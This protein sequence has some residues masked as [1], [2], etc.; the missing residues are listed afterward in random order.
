MLARQQPGGTLLDWRLSMILT[1][2]GQ[3]EEPLFRKI[4]EAPG[5]YSD[6]VVRFCRDGVST[7]PLF[8]GLARPYG[9]TA[10]V[11]EATGG[12]DDPPVSP[13]ASS[14]PGTAVPTLFPI[15]RVL[16]ISRL[17]NTLFS[18]GVFA[19]EAMIRRHLVR[20]GGA[21]P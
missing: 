18:Q 21:L 8:D 20:T 14:P 3:F 6:H 17:V 19:D 13:M 1:Y 11:A 2:L 9:A 5:F 15:P 7:H 16:W 10:A 4:E 12:L